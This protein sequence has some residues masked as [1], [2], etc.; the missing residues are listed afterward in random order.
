MPTD[1]EQQLARFAEALDREAPTISFDDMVG[2]GTVAVDVDLLERP[3]SDRASRVNGVP[4]IDTTPSHDEI[5]E[6]DVLIELAPAVAARRP[7]WRRVALKVAL[8]VAAVAVLV[9]ALAA[10]ERGGDELD[11]ADDFPNLTTTFV[12][13]RNG[14]SVE[15]PDRGRSRSHRPRSSGDS[16]TQVDDGF[17]VVETGSGAVF[18]GASTAVPGRARL[19]RRIRSTSTSSTT[20]AWRLRCAS[21]PA[22]RDHHRWAVG[23]DRGVS[24]PDRGDRRRRRSALSL[25]PVARPQ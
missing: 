12:S 5:G 21:Q 3:S 4:W 19:D 25:H 8:G 13:P 10:I 1:L 22:G 6:R 14:F 18:K 7:A 15:H 16:A 2:R 11:P 24:E 20:S 9:V 17:D 23:Q